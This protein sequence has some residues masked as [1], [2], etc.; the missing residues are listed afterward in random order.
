MNSI[1]EQYD[2]Y[3]QSIYLT[4]LEKLYKTEEHIAHLQVSMRDG[5]L[6]NFDEAKKKDTDLDSNIT[7]KIND[8]QRKLQT[9]LDD[10]LNNL[11]NRHNTHQVEKTELLCEFQAIRD[12][13]EKALKLGLENL[14]R[15]DML[16]MRI[17]KNKT[18]ISK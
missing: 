13:N 18:L 3:D 14:H 2:D 15:L 17:G 6:K 11:Q 5:I 9:R 4:L 16:E 8:L 1:E 10:I 12:E 7:N